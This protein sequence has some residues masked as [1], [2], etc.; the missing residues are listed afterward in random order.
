MAESAG[1]IWTG[2]HHVRSASS[3]KMIYE[4]PAPSNNL[5]L[6][7]PTWVEGLPENDWDVLAIQPHGSSGNT[8][9]HDIEY[10]L[11]FRDAAKSQGRNLEMQ[12]YVYS[13]WPLSTNW[14]DWLTPVPNE[15]TQLTV[16]RRQFYEHVAARLGDTLSQPVH[17]IPAGDVLYRL[18]QEIEAGTIP[19]ITSMSELYRDNLHMSYGYGRFVAGSTV[20][21]TIAGINPMGIVADDEYASM[22]P[23]TVLRIQEI[24]WDVVA[25]H[26][27]SGV[28]PI[29]GDYNGDESVDV[30]DYQ[31]WRGSFGKSMSYAADGNRDGVINAADYTVWRDHYQMSLSAEAVA[32]PEPT[33]PTLLC[34][35]AVV[36][37]VAARS[38]R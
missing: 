26:P 6:P 4:N 29:P 14:A 27:R 15:L 17:V 9:G 34:I 20:L 21:A 35:A 31:W 10:A 28:S 19:N 13:T 36:A 22:E 2:G 8:M 37:W 7:G 38:R 23:E 24:V 33:G 18:K 5:S 12:M 16:H 1:L 11:R 32:V 30:A 3:I 25:N